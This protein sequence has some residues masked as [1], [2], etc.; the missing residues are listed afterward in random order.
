MTILIFTEGTVL[1]HGSAKGKTREQIV[2]Q[3]KKFG[4]QTVVRFF[5]GGIHD[6][7]SYIPVHNAVERIKKWKE[8]GATIYYLSSRRVKEEI[9]A[10]RN[11][12][13]K[14]CF[15]GSQNLLYRQ[16]GEEYNDVAEKLMPDILIEDD[17]ESI[18]G[19]KEMT[20]T[21]M[22]D[23]A[24]PR[25]HSIAVKKFSGIDYLPDSMDQ[26]KAYSGRP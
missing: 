26:L 4:I 6:Y 13:K 15:P 24:K 7:Q 12:L 3:S 8:Q 9:E 2:Q 20:Y 18:G 14:Y 19:E 25:V 10:I 5:P 21:H 16:Q 11:V 17:C 23:D 1:M 22:S